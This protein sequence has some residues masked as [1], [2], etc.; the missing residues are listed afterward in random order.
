MGAHTK[1][2]WTATR[3]ADG[4][5]APGYTF[6]PW[7]GCAKVSPGCTNCYAET[8]SKRNPKVLGTWG[9]GGTRPVASES[10]WRQPVS[11]NR[12]AKRAGERRKVFCASLADVCEDRPDLVEPRRRL[13]MLI[14]DTPHLDWLL[15]TKRPENLARL[16]D[17]SWL[18]CF[19][20][21]EWPPNVWLGTT[22]EN[23]EQ[24]D[25]RVPLL[26]SVPAS[27]HFLSA[28]PLLGPL[29]LDR[30]LG[31]VKW[32]IIG[33]ESGTVA[34]PG[35]VDWARPIVSKC[36]EVGVACFMKQVGRSFRAN[37][38]DCVPAVAMGAGWDADAPGSEKGLV[39]P[40]DPKGGN[41]AEWPKDLRV[42][43]W[44]L[45]NGGIIA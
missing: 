28:E 37:R 20:A 34:R 24:A 11:W 36:S 25:I 40:L 22:V 2:E 18:G 16:F 7:R 42:R 19:D 23:Q 15:L 38:T 26:L 29:N 1:I 31:E 44:P 30:W 9:V 5:L 27:T 21:E 17:W 6:N 3:R 12:D 39:F 13:M 45:P 41:P 10:Y 8:L 32:V 33:F 14:L 4:S 43:Q 35:D